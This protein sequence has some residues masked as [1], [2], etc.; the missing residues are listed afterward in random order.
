MDW[1][2][3]GQ[4]ASIRFTGCDPD[5]ADLPRTRRP[6][7]ALAGAGS[8]FSSQ[9]GTAEAATS[10]RPSCNLGPWPQF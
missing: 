6:W 9:P 2:I 7:P 10:V 5:P 8:R 4:D 1:P 3:A